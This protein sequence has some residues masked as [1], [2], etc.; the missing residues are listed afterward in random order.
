ME[1]Y[2]KIIN[3]NPNDAD[4]WYYLGSILFRENKLNEALD[5][6]QKAV[7]INPKHFEAY[8]SLGRVLCKLGKYK[9]SLNAYDKALEIYPNSS[10]VWLAK[11]KLQNTYRTGKKYSYFH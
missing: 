4:S 5:A 8:N 7:Q 6:Y 2:V 10:E 1:I 9:N 11:A 3:I